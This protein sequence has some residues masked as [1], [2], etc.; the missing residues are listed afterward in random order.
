VGSVLSRETSVELQSKADA[1]IWA[2]GHADGAVTRKAPEG[3][4]RSET[5]SRTKAT[6]TG[7]GRS[8]TRRGA[9]S[10]PA[11]VGKSEDEDRR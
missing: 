5:R 8:R 7:T 3:S 11:A 4:A 9:M 10:S 1:V 6:C 2:E